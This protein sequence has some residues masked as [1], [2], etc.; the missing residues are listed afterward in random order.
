MK[1]ALT[2]IYVKSGD[3]STLVIE[4]TGPVGYVINKIE[5]NTYEIVIDGKLI[6]AP[7]EINVHD[8]L[9]DTITVSEKNGKSIVATHLE[10]PSLYKVEKVSGIPE[11]LAI[12]FDW[13]YIKSLLKNKIIVIDPGHGGK[14]KGHRGYIN[15]LEKDVVLHIAQY[16]KEKLNLLGASS[17]L[18][19]EKDI[20]LSLKDRVQIASLL[21]ADLFISLH[22]HWDKD[23]S[24]CGCRGTY[25]G[26]QSHILCKDII[27][28]LGKKLRLNNIGIYE[29]N[30]Y[31]DIFKG[32]YINQI[33][34]VNISICTISNPVE[35]GWLRSPVFK[36]RTAQSVMNGITKFLQKIVKPTYSTMS[37]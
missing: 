21:E 4:S 1:S 17:I 20:A 36:E 29:E 31:K 23:K 25:I 8:G 32:N 7:D 10:Y 37:S 24:I 3:C 12:S 13:L 6:M 28:E 16:L 34:Y 35:E 18:T 22:T 19:R 14:D 27:E 15:L 9:I 33:P 26:Q 30:N 5:R 11:R 2:N